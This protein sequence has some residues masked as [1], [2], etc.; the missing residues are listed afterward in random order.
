MN[1]TQFVDSLTQLTLGAA[2]GEATT[3]RKIGNRALLWGAIGGTLPDFDVL[4]NFMTDEITAMAFH[5]GI[6]HSLFFAFTAPFLL[7]WMTHRFYNSGFYNAPGGKRLAFWSW[8]LFFLV[9]LG[10][11]NVAI[12]YMTG[13]V[14]WTVLLLATGL[15]AWLV[16]FFYRKYYRRSL[17][18]VNAAYRDW[19]LLW[20]VSI[21]T[22]PLLDSCTAYGTQLFQPFSDYR[23][24]WNNISVADPL[25]TLPFLIFLIFVYRAGRLSKQRRL[26][27]TLA[28]TLSSAY[29]CFTVFN[30]LN[31]DRVFETSLTEQNIPYE[32][33]TASPSI[34]NN[35]LW[36]GTAETAEGYYIGSYSIMDPTERVL[37]FNRLDK[38]HELLAPYEGQRELEILQWFTKDY[39]QVR[40]VDDSTYR[41]NDLRYGTRSGGATTDPSD[42]I[43]SF[44][45]VDRNGQL[46][47]KGNSRNADGF[48]EEWLGRYYR[49]VMGE[50]DAFRE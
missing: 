37:R 23:V 6:T 27:N 21:V 20:F 7:A 10:G 14:N 13:A 24:A 47:M 35:L 40:R 34:L 45:L 30:K 33:Y 43:F 8:T 29:L 39:Y 42:F 28:F 22:H 26:W 1:Q 15:F 3:G 32:R 48:G 4:A 50:V 31:V 41:F 9:V 11:P 36:Q 16:W 25:Y 12:V 18:P 49:R 44:E 46:E 19:V 2:C 17:P 38:N 5:R